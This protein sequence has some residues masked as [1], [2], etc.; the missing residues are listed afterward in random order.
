MMEILQ[1]PEAWIAL[2]SLTVLEIVLGIDNI[3]FIAILTSR[4]PLHQQ[5]TAY[6]LGLGAAMISRIGLLLAINWVMRL[7]KELF[8]VFDHGITGRELIL[9]GGGIFLIGKSAHEI[10]DNVEGERDGGLA[11]P[12]KKP[13][14]MGSVVGQIMILDMIFS[15]DSVVTAVGVADDI[16]VMV[17]AIVVAVIVM[18][19][20]AKPV[21]DFVTKNPSM[22]ILALSFLL[23]IGVLLTAEAFEQ[24][25]D[26]GYIYFAMGFALLVEL[27][28]MRSSK[29]RAALAVRQAE[30]DAAVGEK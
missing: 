16:E 8:S 28:N 21:G 25:V 14:T 19:V 24:H 12:K 5:K 4:L 22:K 11:R 17:I 15:L 30:V 3:V 2:V 18:L 7:E 23:L 13:A 9:L 10:Y 6:R 20:F 27:L 29:K 26:K 1:S